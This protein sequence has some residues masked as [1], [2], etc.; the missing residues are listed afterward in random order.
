MAT[1]PRTIE[2]FGRLAEAGGWRLGE[3]ME[4]AFSYNLLMGKR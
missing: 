2:A 1:R 4:R 3:V